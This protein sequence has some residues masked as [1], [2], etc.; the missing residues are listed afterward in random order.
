[1]AEYDQARSDWDRATVR[2]GRCTST[3]PVWRGHSGPGL[4][5]LTLSTSVRISSR[6]LAPC[7]R[8]GP[9]L[10]SCPG[11]SPCH[12]A[13]SHLD[14]A[15]PCPGYR[16]KSGLH[17]NYFVKTASRAQVCCAHVRKFPGIEGHSVE[18]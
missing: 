17:L 8:D 5:H 18:I 6:D 15:S 7:H 16:S 13:C 1:M 12:D 14:S 2:C 9:C 11:L 10:C 4:I 3:D